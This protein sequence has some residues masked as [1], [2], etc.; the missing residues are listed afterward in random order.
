MGPTQLHTALHHHQLEQCR[1]RRE[2][3]CKSPVCLNLFIIMN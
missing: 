1:F 3:D 2:E